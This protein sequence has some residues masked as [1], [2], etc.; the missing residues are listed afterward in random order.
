M[1]N[2]IHEPDIWY[3]TLFLFEEVA[4]S[5]PRYADLTFELSQDFRA[6]TMFKNETPIALFTRQAIDIAE[7]VVLEER[8]DLS[9]SDAGRLAAQCLI[10]SSLNGLSPFSLDGSDIDPIAPNDRPPTLSPAGAVPLPSLSAPIKVLEL[11]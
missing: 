1:C 6:I 2:P 5:Q 11:A 8:P 3:E 7:E 9:D 4:E 10:E